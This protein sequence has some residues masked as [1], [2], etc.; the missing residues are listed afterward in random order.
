MV[1]HESDGWD[2]TSAVTSLVQLILDPHFRTLRG[3]VNCQLA[4]S[5]N[6]STNVFRFQ[7]LIEKE[8]LRFGHPFSS[9]YGHSGKPFSQAANCAPVLMVFLD[10]VW[11]VRWVT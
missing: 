9:R 7:Q 5:L 1:V 6:P 11:Q 4:L 8:W 3:C 2:M 10:C